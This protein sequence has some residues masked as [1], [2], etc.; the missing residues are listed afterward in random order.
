MVLEKQFRDV[1][2]VQKMRCHHEQRLRETEVDA[3]FGP[4]VK[5][6]RRAETAVANEFGAN[7]VILHLAVQRYGLHKMHH[8]NR[9]IL[10]QSE[11]LVRCS[12]LS[13]LGIN[14]NKLKQFPRQPSFIYG[15]EEFSATPP[16]VAG[17]YGE[18]VQ[19][20]FVGNG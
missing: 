19:L 18:K 9:T 16:R 13:S 20:G 7:G 1:C 17:W 2:R 12:R 5:G 11:S 14:Y 10:A 3:I 6:K 15:G 8:V 4:Y